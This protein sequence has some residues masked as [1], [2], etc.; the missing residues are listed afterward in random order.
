MRWKV[1][2]FASTF[3]LSFEKQTSVSVSLLYPVIREKKGIL[4]I[5]NLQKPLLNKNEKIISV[6]F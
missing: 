3:F 1:G 2:N 6:K 4:Q 5:Q